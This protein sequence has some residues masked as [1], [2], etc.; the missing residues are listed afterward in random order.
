MGKVAQ[1]TVVLEPALEEFIQS[2]VERGSF[3]SSGDYIKQI[4]QQRYEQAR[5]QRIK[6]LD[7]ALDEGIAQADAG[8]LIP[9]D[10]AFGRI[11]KTLGLDKNKA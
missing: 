11:R 2:E 6:D 5:L 8:L 1:I 9:I 3:A 10:E 4:L 7:E